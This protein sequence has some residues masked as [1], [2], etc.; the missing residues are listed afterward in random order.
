MKVSLFLCMRQ[1]ACPVHPEEFRAG[2]DIPVTL[3]RRE[4]ILEVVDSVTRTLA[5][6]TLG[7]RQ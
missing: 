6:S 3:A 1:L 7:N 5:L 2:Q 4:A